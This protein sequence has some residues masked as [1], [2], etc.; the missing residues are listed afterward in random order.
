MLNPTCSEQISHVPNTLS[1]NDI[2]P[3]N[4]PIRQANLSTNHREN[5]K[6]T[7]T[8][9][10]QEALRLYDFGLNVFPQPLGKKGGLPWA[11]FQYTRLERN[12]LAYGVSAIFA[13]QCNLA[14]MCGKT[15]GNLF[16]IDCETKQSFKHHT[17]ELRKRKIPLWTAKTARGG[18]IYLRCAE[19]EVA[20]IEAGKIPDTEIKGCRH[21]VLAP[22]SRHP[23][24]L[25]YQW[26]TQKSQEPPTI[27]LEEINWLT[28][29][30]GNPFSLTLDRPQRRKKSPTTTQAAPKHTN[31]KLSQA[32]LDY[33]ANGH[34]IQE[35]SRNNRLFSAACDMIGNDYSETD[36][37]Q[38]LS[39]IA[40][41]SGLHESE[42]RRTLQ[43]ALS[44]QREPAKP[45]TENTTR[46]PIWLY[47]EKFANQHT[48]EG[49]T[50]GSDQAIF[51]A[52]IIRC[53]QGTN[54]NGIFRASI[55]EL[56]TAARVGTETVQNA[57]KRLKNANLI[58]RASSDKTSGANLWRFS[59]KVIN[60]G[61]DSKTDT[62]IPSPP[63]LNY[64]V[65]VFDSDLVER[66]AL[67]RNG[68]QLYLYLR[69]T[70]SAQMPMA[71][72]AGAS[73]KL[74]QV[75]YAL[76][77]LKALG[78]VVRLSTGW[79]AISVD[80]V[81]LSEEIP[82]VLGVS[83]NGNSRKQR[84]AYER[85]VHAGRIVHRARFVQEGAFWHTGDCVVDSADN[86]S[87][88]VALVRFWQCPNCGQ[89]V[90]GDI[91]PDL[92]D[93][94]ADL[95]TWRLLPRDDLT[96]GDDDE[97]DPLIALARELGGV[98]WTSPPSDAA[99]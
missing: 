43:S 92:C 16:V 23:T 44:K 51:R 31:S 89:K 97:E 73:L 63:W 38:Q 90:F 14:I 4:T 76:S 27:A 45:P 54:E 56:A 84:Y 79:S 5:D 37:I 9:L 10:Q 50:A 69:Y 41:A 72:A 64:S 52:L 83:G 66:G 12:H 88:K 77:K 15:S 6:P 48:W 47:A 96:E 17:S 30:K 34:R 22:P 7:Q 61:R 85:A 24:G 67:G 13:G 19:G 39:H 35:G 57:L 36:V 11:R 81:R 33:L 20:N 62:L 32:T 71:I 40:Q 91:P 80:D 99:L 28:D 49:R 70:G 78:L 87:S 46:K 74:H 68:L 93:F 95:T 82:R 55:R 59:D 98:L 26:G 60:K 94:C 21:Y 1:V 42:V 65:S 18:H 86:P 75:Y 8:A 53:K 25:T 2:I 29:L 58:F 3:H